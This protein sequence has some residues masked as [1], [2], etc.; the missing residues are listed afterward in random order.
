M[1]LARPALPALFTSTSTGPNSARTVR[2]AET[3]ESQS[4]T[5]PTETWKE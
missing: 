3:V 5:L 1:V 4:P 2:N